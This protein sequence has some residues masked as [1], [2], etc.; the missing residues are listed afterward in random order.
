M[1]IQDRRSLIVCLFAF[2]VLAARPNA[3]AQ[4][5]LP[6]AHRRRPLDIF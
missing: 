5:T 1:Q 4:A 3:P 6:R 2:A